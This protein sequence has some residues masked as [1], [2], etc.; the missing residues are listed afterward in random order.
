M[1]KNIRMDDCKKRTPSETHNCL[2]SPKK[3]H[4]VIFICIPILTYFFGILSIP[5][6]FSFL[7]ACCFSSLFL[8]VKDRWALPLIVSV[9]VIAFLVMEIGLRSI[10]TNSHPTYYRPHEKY[11]SST[12]LGY[13]L[14]IVEN[15]FR[16]PYGDLFVLSNFTAKTIIEPRVVNFQTDSLGFR[17]SQDYT[18]QPF[19]LIGDSYGVSCSTSQE[20][21]L[22]E[23]LTREHDI[24][25]YNASYPTDPYG[26]I[27]ICRQLTK[28]IGTEFKAIIMFFEGNDFYTEW[29]L[30]RPWY[31]YNP[32]QI[33]EL[34]CYRLFFGLTR[35]AFYNLSIINKESQVM[36]STIGK[37]D[38]GFYNPYVN[39]SKQS[40]K[41][42]WTDLV[43]EYRQIKDNIALFIFVPT[44]YRVYY[45]LMKNNDY[46][47]L[48]NI[49]RDLVQEL[50]LEIDIPFV[51]LTPYLVEMSKKLLEKGEYS[52]WRDDT[53][54]NQNGTKIAADAIS[55][56][57]TVFSIE[58]T[59][60][61]KSSVPDT[62]K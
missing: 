2:S 8:F 39:A 6:F 44:K 13:K 21:M 58:S 50:A 19:V 18:G 25:V 46:N 40:T 53:H 49:P 32:H 24:P 1:D 55:N 35:R 14:G 48:P 54:W 47:T 42:D 38:V 3:A 11:F 33:R 56:K 41:L 23:T 51:D 57:L 20:Y 16:M 4:K 61:S 45:P 34:E 17:N 9:L 30:Q 28:D 27:T 22:S 31:L 15:Q 43:D 62:D 5:L 10:G 26:Y 52:F 7:I 59:S 37:K 36:I 12:G 29:K 60:N